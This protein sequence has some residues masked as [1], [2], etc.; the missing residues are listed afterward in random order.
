MG[1]S[2]SKNTFFQKRAMRVMAGLKTLD[3]WRP[4]FKGMEDLESCQPLR[5]VEESRQ[6]VQCCN[7]RQLLNHQ[8]LT[9]LMQTLPPLK[10]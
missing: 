6:F 10:H 3:S 4:V 7:L 1:R 9:C 8:Y 2:I 5:L